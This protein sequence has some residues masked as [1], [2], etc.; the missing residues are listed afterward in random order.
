MVLISVEPPANL[1][2]SSKPV[3]YFKR[4]LNNNQSVNIDLESI[5]KVLHFLFQGVSH[6]IKIVFQY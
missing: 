5:V 2:T 3:V 6:E 1:Q 4:Q